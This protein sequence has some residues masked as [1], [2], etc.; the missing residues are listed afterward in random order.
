MSYAQ[1]TAIPPNALAWMESHRLHLPREA[2]DVASRSISSWQNF[3]ALPLLALGSLTTN[4]ALNYIVQFDIGHTNPIISLPGE[5]VVD[6]MNIEDEEELRGFLSF[7][8]AQIETHPEWIEP[9]DQSQLDRLA[10][11]LANVKI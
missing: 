9:A 5:D 11:L 7:L 8:D 2:G 3:A 10:N 4:Q 1:I 6:W